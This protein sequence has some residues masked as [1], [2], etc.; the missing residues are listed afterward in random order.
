[1][2]KDPKGP[3]EKFEWGV[4]KIQGEKHGKTKKGKKGAGKDIRLVGNDV[5]KWKERKGH[6]LTKDMITGIYDKNIDTLIIG[7]GADEMLECP[8][9]VKK[10][11]YGHGVQELYIENTPEAC[12]LYNQ[13]YRQNRKVALLAHGTC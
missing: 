2:Y 4:F 3:I 8:E 1:M 6:K 13:T 11:I 7:N 9:E 12:R 10:D 5:S